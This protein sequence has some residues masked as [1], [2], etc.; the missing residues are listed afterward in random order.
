MTFWPQARL[1]TRASNCPGLKPI[2]TH[3][4]LVVLGNQLMPDPNS[5]Q[6]GWLPS[7]CAEEGQPVCGGMVSID[8]DFFVNSS[9]R[10][11]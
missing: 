3:R 11:T 7:L 9:F 4:G 10:A 8:L 2:L 5:V 6:L 1:S